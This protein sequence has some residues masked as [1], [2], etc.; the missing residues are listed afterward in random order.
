[1][2]V[3]TAQEFVNLIVKTIP[4][5]Y[6]V[7]QY[8]SQLKRDLLLISTR[9]NPQIKVIYRKAFSLLTD[10]TV[11]FDVNPLK[12]G[13]WV[14]EAELIVKHEGKTLFDS[15]ISNNATEL[16]EIVKLNVKPKLF[17][18]YMETNNEIR[19]AQTLLPM[20]NHN[21]ERQDTGN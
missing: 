20:M 17:S 4:T 16:F 19:V 8:D 15:S 9:I 21:R 12:E 7:A 5:S 18:H 3:M 13:A 10:G 6:A 11:F 14:L 1:M 2:R